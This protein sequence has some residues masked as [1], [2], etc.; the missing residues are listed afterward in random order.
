[1]ACLPAAES[2]AD[3]SSAGDANAVLLGEALP[4]F[5]DL[6]QSLLQGAIAGDDVVGDRESLVVAG[7]GADTGVRLLFGHPAQPHEPINPGLGTRVHHHDA[8]ELGGARRCTARRGLDQKWHVIDHHRIR[9]GLP[10]CS[11]ELAG[12]GTNGGVGDCIE[13]CSLRGIC[14]N[15]RTECR[16]IE[17]AIGRDHRG[18]EVLGD[19]RERRGAGFNDLAGDTVG[20]DHHRTQLSETGSD[21]GFA[22]GNASS[23]SDELHQARLAKAHGSPGCYRRAQREDPRMLE[24]LAGTGLAIAAGLNAY[25]PLLVLGLAG[26][27]VPF[28]ELPASWEWLSNDWVLIILGVLAVIEFIADKIPAVDTVNDW[29][30]TLVRPASGGIVFGTGAATTTDAIADPSGFFADGQWTSIAIGAL[31][32]LGVH[33]LKASIRPALNAMT[34]GIAAPVA[35]AAEDVGSVLLSLLALLLPV[36][37][38]VAL[39]GIIVG[40]ILL[41]RR[42]AAR[43][44]VRA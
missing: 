39:I 42:L 26:R 32:A 11:E 3:N 36:F 23:D 15:D 16:T 40:A 31:L 14:K 10:R 37:V 43:R 18:S 28:I 17:R 7:L 41:V 27:F 12:P 33:A 6:D 44:R 24:L 38:A 2:T 19:C 20:I 30:Q 21:D 29:I 13:N 9:V 8:V 35:S 4:E 5:V 25:I 34:G 22:R 1:M